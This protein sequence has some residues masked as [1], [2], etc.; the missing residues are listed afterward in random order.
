MRRRART[1]SPPGGQP[2][3]C[4]GVPPQTPLIFGSPAEP[5][6]TFSFG[7]YTYAAAGLMPPVVTP[8]VSQ[9]DGSVQAVQVTANPGATTDPSQA[10]A[11]FGFGF[12]NPGSPT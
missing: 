7:L 3:A 1:I 5:I 9:S 8:S 12:G 6:G 11:G 2:K 4:V 10:F